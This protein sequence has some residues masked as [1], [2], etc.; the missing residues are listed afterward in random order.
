[1][2]NINSIFEREKTAN[3]MKQLLT[4]F[5]ENCKIITFKKGIYVYGSPGC[6]KSHFV[7]NLL[8]ELD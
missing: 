6:G 1:M 5:E 7:K 2:E 8:K 3:E 4:G